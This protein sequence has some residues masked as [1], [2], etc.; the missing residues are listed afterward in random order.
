MAN[1]GEFTGK[2]STHIRFGDFNM[3]PPRV[4]IVRSA[5]DDIL[6]EYDF[7]LVKQTPQ[8]P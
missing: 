7:R 8:K 6:L 2:A 3:T 5:V 1:G 4:P